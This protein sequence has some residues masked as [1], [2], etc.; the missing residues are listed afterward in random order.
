MLGRKDFLIFII[1][2]IISLSL[3]FDLFTNNARPASF[4]GLTHI[5]NIAQY[6]TALKDG[7]FP[8]RW[9]DGFANYGMPIPIFGHQITSYLG[10]VLTFFTNNPLVSYNIVIFI[11]AFMSTIGIYLFL[12]SY[13]DFFSSLFGSFLLTY[14]P[15]RIINIYVRGAAPEFF[16]TLFFPLILLSLK[17]WTEKN[18][19]KWFFSFIILTSLL[20]QTHPIAGMI[21]FIFII[22][23]FLIVLKG[24]HF[25]RLLAF[26]LGILGAIGIAS[27]Y[28]FPLLLEFKYFYYGQQSEIFLPN[29]FLTINNFIKPNWPYFFQGD[30]LTRGHYLHIGSIEMIITIVYLI[31]FL[32]N[33][34]RKYRKF[35]SLPLVA[36]CIFCIYSFFMS[37]YASFI[38]L[39]ISFLGNIQHQWR[40]LSG[41]IIIPPILGAFLVS[42]LK[43][44]LRRI[45][46]I[47]TIVIII[48]IRFPQLYGKNYILENKNKYSSNKENLYASI[49]NTI[50]TGKTEDYPV[51]KFK[52]EIIEGNGKIINRN[53]H[54]SWREYEIDAKTDLRLADYTFYFPGWKVFV[55]KNEVPIEFQDMNY[56]GVITYRIPQGKHT[57]LVKFTD[58]KIR[59]LANITSLFSLGTLGLMIIFRKKLFRHSAKKRS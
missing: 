27:Y 58:T 40:M 24:Y 48:I 50:W 28:V 37:S 12:H 9:Q 30:I 54:N 29:Q 55:D 33:G 22:P 15:Y 34:R 53:E 56:R 38:Y 10:G 1:L 52:G 6:Y 11:S 7:D 59:L 19:T 26:S 21:Q 16:S 8:V 4:D 43:E 45:I 3:C 5:T 49:Y 51:K 42:I 31:Y 41:L 17:K 46:V 47:I 23:Y 18:D 39:K 25:N 36:F 32:I 14:A 44:K 13:Y 57:V 2:F 35:Q 20:I